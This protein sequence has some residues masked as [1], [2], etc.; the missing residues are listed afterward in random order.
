MNA[1]VAPSGL[2]GAE[3]ARLELLRHPDEFDAAVRA[4]LA[5]AEQR[6][7]QFGEGW[8]RVLLAT[9]LRD[10]RQVLFAVLRRGD[11]VRAVL[12]LL[13]EGGARWSALGNYYTYLYAPA[14]A[15]D[16]GT[17]ELAA[18]FAALRRRVP[19]ARIGLAPLDRETPGYARLGEALRHAGLR[20]YPFLC[21]GNWY[22]PVAGR[23]SE[24]LAARSANFRSAL[25]RNLKRFESAGGRITLHRDPASAEPALQAYMAVYARSW[26]KPEPYPDFIPA[27][28]RHSA[29]R[30]LLRM[31]V[32]WVG[33][34]PVAAQ[35]WLVQGRKADI[36]KLAYD[37]AYKDIAPGV[38][39]TARLFEQ[40]IDED[41]VTEVDYLIGDD[42]YKK[43]WMQQRRERWGWMAYNPRHPAG[44]LG[45]L[46]EA[47]WRRLKPLWAAR[48]EAGS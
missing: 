10:P 30:G 41:G 47:L 7:P 12:P 17:G 45:W 24:Y 25:R 21:F 19:M 18:L 1:A 34:Q 39:L 11:E 32:A 26:K 4:L 38:A 44:L 42:D 28:V 31:G 29:A 23:W 15:A 27:L 22:E 36:Y 8:Y 9:V 46:K 37:E 40:A 3:R 14:L 33:E 48:A 2:H 35:I 43:R 16:C 13:H 6:C 20:P 5:A